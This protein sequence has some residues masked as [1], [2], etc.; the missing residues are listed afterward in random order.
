MPAMNPAQERRLERLETTVGPEQEQE[1]T[2]AAEHGRALETWERFAGLV[3]DDLS[4]RVAAVLEDMQH[5]IWRWLRNVFEGKSRL[6]EC[7]TENVMRQ[8]LL[9][10]LDRAELCD[11]SEMACLRCG[12]QY[13]MHK[14]PPLSEWK[15]TPAAKER[16]A[17][18][19]PWDN[20]PYPRYDLPH[21]FDHAGCPAC[22]ASSRAEEANWAHLVE[23]GYWF[24]DEQST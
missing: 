20:L 13:P 23:S 18:G 11:N 22:G 4:E 8:I 9:V 12:L 19:C 17:Q 7:L 1:A 16:L 21:F 10:R 6:P 2:Q 3:P 5:P 14:S 24:A 15:M